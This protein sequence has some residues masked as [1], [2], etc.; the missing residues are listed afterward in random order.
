MGHPIVHVRWGGGVIME[1][2]NNLIRFNYSKIGY[3]KQKK[4]KNKKKRTEI[5]F[6]EIIKVFL[7]EKY[8]F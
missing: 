1:R 6:N 8:T 3:F 5:S 7:S 2:R 4:K